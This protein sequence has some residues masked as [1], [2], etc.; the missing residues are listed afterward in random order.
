MSLLLGPAAWAGPFIPAGD[1]ALRHD[2]QR[3]ADAGIIKGPTTTWPLAWGPILDDLRQ[4]DP[5][6]LHPSVVASLTRVR[7]R[8]NWETRTGL[9]TFKSKVGGAENPTRVRSFQD[10]PRG[11]IE[12]AAGVGWIGD[13]FSIELNLQGVDSDQDR[14]ELRADDSMIGVMLGNWSVAASTQQR[15]WGPGWDGSLI[16]SNNARPIPSL[17]IDR[18]FTDAFKTKWLSWIGPWDLAVVFGQLESDRP[19]APPL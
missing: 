3:L 18:V 7:D 15:W 9:L 10:T 2:I 1:M 13:R 4:A 12:I 8:A 5:S 16:L 14:E 19:R 6:S 17:T 11:T